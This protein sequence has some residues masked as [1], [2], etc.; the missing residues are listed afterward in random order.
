MINTYLK[1]CK[2]FVLAVVSCGI[3]L[4]LFLWKFCNPDNINNGELP[5]LAA[6]F[7][8]GVY[9]TIKLSSYQ[10][11]LC[12]D[13]IIRKLW[14]RKKEIL[15]RDIDRIIINASCFDA[16][17]IGKAINPQIFKKFVKY[18]IFDV[19]IIG[20]E[21]NIHFKTKWFDSIKQINDALSFLIEKCPIDKL[22]RNQCTN[23]FITCDI[24]MIIKWIIVFFILKHVA[25]FFF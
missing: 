24:K 1:P 11:L 3:I 18:Q 22:Q 6:I 2:A 10:L 15:Y 14:W 16:Y 4:S 20:N 19:W 13:R 7:A 25:S 5:V 17:K 23:F 9:L 21:C 12:N 8:I